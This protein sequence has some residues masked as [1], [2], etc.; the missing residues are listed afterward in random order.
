MF[1]IIL[2]FVLMLVVIWP[3]AAYAYIGPGLGVAL[4]WTLL[5]PVAA[6]VTA[7]LMVAY[8]PARY[9]YKKYK[10]KRTHDTIQ[11]SLSEDNENS[12]EVE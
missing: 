9:Y 8:F 3:M 4:A 1:R 7:V 5:G 10:A 11:E 12:E 6:V 2:F